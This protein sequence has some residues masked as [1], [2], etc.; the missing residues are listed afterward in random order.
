MIHQNSGKSLV[1]GCAV[2]DASAGRLRD[3]RSRLCRTLFSFGSSCDGQYGHMVLLPG[4]GICGYTN[5]NE[6]TWSLSGEELCLHGR[7]GKVTS[8]Y[9]E[10]SHSGAWFGKFQGTI[11][12]LYLVPVLQLS[13]G[14]NESLKPGSGKPSFL[15]NT[16]PKS[17]THYLESALNHMG[18]PSQRMLLGGRDRVDDFRG[19]TADGTHR[20]PGSRRLRCP[21]YLV[22]AMLRGEHVLGHIAVP[23]ELA[24]V[25]GQGVHIIYTIRNLR[26]VLT[27][28]YRYK[29]TKVVATNASDRY[30][31]SLEEPARLPAFLLH[32]EEEFQHQIRMA[33]VIL[34]DS[35]GIVLRYEDMCNG[36]VTP[37]A[38]PRL[39]TI[40]PGFSVRLRDALAAKF[41]SANPTFSGKISNWRDIWN[42]DVERFF[43]EAGLADANRALGYE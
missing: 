41:G 11:W 43:V 37:Q 27:S 1:A 21:P 17:G 9:L 6:Q 32:F 25:K 5:R 39:D 42:R 38:V 15:V 29:L 26:D 8:R 28:L 3:T 23:D 24:K 12:P 33:N 10:C 13:A 4:G 14:V 34:A 22:T 7:D 30:W 20:N 36:I 16:I 35:D 31:R 2:D 40:N 19:L 18:F